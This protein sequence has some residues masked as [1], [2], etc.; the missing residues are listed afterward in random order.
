M[1]AIKPI[2]D[3]S[4][5]KELVEDC[6]GVYNPDFFAYIAN[7]CDEQA[8]TVRYSIGCCQ[9]GMKNGRGEISLL[10]TLPGVEDD[11]A[12]MIMAR[13][14]ASFLFRCDIRYLIMHPGAAE[15]PLYEKLG[16]ALNSDGEQEL[17]L[18]RYYTTPCHDR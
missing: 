7:E 4:V 1:L 9:F 16:F 14:A 8:E 13:A 11:E 18:L 15:S 5:Q 3:K 12:L 6:G 10:R 17:D 2:Q